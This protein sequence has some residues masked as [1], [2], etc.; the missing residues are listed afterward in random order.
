MS[1][2]EKIEI[3]EKEENGRPKSIK[4]FGA[5]GNNLKRNLDVEFS[6]WNYDSRNRVSGSGKSSLVKMPHYIQFC[7]IS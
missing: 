1:G 3:P 5:K 2:K 4:L 6:S 7:L